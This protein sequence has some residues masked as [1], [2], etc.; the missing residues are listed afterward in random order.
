MKNWLKIISTIIVVLVIDLITKHFLFNVSYFNLIPNII[1]IA[2]N[3]GNDGAAWGIMSGKTVTLIIISCVMLVALF[4]YNHFVKNKNTFY[5]LGFGFMVGGAIG[6][7]VDRIWLNYVRDFIYLDFWP[8]FP[9]FNI[10]D[11]FLCVGTVI[12]AIFI[13]F[14]VTKKEN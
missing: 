9:T 3:G 1:S 4:I 2:S 13:V 10:A 5:C 11:S 6:N 7:L 8:T 14:G 12:M